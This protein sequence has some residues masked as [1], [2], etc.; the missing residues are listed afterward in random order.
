MRGIIKQMVGSHLLCVV[1]VLVLNIVL[2]H[3]PYVLLVVS[4]RASTVTDI[5][6]GNVM[7]Y[8]ILVVW[9]ALVNFQC[10]SCI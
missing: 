9:Y 7:V 2:H 4:L 10:K 3:F 5:V 1:Y 6:V 8:P